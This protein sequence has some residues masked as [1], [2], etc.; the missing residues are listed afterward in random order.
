MKFNLKET[1]IKY[2]LLREGWMED[3][4]AEYDEDILIFVGRILQKVYGNENIENHKL[5]KWIAETTKQMGKPPYDV[6]D[7]KMSSVVHAIKTI[8]EY[9]KSENDSDES[10][11]NIKSKKPKE[12]Y[13]FA[14]EELEKTKIEYPESL[15]NMIDNNVI[16]I[17]KELSDG[18]IWVEVL[19][20]S[21]FDTKSESRADYGIACQTNNGPGAKFVGGSYKTYTLLAKLKTYTDENVYNK[22]VSIA[23]DSESKAFK[24]IKDAG[25]V[26]P[27]KSSISGWNDLAEVTSDFLLQELGDIDKFYAWNSNQVPTTCSGSYGAS[28][29][30]C[31]WLDKRVDIIDKLLSRNPS[32]LDS[33]EPL[34]RSAKPDFLELL[35]IDYEKLIEE[36]PNR[37]FNKLNVFLTRMPEGLESLLKNFD[38]QSYVGSSSGKEAIFKNLLILIE[39]LSFKFFLEKIYPYIDFSEFLSKKDKNGIENILRSIRNKYNKNTSLFL[40]DFEKV[41]KD[42]VNGLGGGLK[43]FG[44]LAK[45]LNIPRLDKHQNF[46]IVDGEIIASV[47]SEVDGN[48]QL[49]DVKIPEDDKVLDAKNIRNFYKKNEEWIKSNISGTDEDKEIQ[50]LRYILMNSS[51]QARESSLKKEKENFI[52][53][54]NKKYKD[55]KSNLPGVLVYNA[56]INPKIFQLTRSKNFVDETS[57]YG[58]N[59]KD[60]KT[61]N[62]NYL[63]QL[64]KFYVS[65]SKRK[66]LGLKL[67]DA[68]SAII[69]TLIHSSF[70]KEEINEIIFNTFAIDKIDKNISGSTIAA[71]ASMLV[72]FIDFGIINPNLAIDFLESEKFK[73]IIEKDSKN[74]PTLSQ[75]YKDVLNKIKNITLNESKVRK[76]I[77]NL[78]NENFKK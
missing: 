21:F 5:A 17:F 33:M 36:D 73:K 3:L 20:K 57:I 62:Y 34:I 29:T 76:Y 26:P 56:M 22:L 8:L 23:L 68:T 42:F 45:I 51:E 41:F 48:S 66:D 61:D 78:L 13:A 16:K 27:G 52:D 2:N 14:K 53:Y 30:F 40:S 50:F 59:K 9:V 28:S 77:F 75:V 70:S 25:N 67:V 60:L 43:G 58:F 54:Y 7:S 65:K 38:F 32:I 71:Y 46:R 15:Q 49:V 69:D 37:F 47:E 18:R 39:N 1:L 63:I 31:Y 10:I 11:E 44:L 64:L 19:D 4:Q 35:E 6:N 12:A 24:E 74:S 72:D 55:K